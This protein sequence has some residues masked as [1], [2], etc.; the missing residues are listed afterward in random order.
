M[1][2]PPP[3]KTP[4]NRPDYETEVRPRS[5]RIS[6]RTLTFFL[7]AVLLL[8]FVAVSRNQS[9]TWKVSAHGMAS[10]K[11]GHSTPSEL[12]AA[13]G[14]PSMTWKQGATHR[15]FRFAGELWR[16][17]CPAG[18]AGIFKD[19]LCATYVGIANGHVQTLWTSDSRYHTGQASFIHAP[20]A[21]LR[22]N[23]NGTWS[24]WKAKC[25]SVIFPSDARATYLAPIL[26][27]SPDSQNG[28]ARAFYVSTVPA[29]FAPCA[30]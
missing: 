15:P 22:K 27:A 28:Y 7:I 8:G 11:I 19:Q 14:E 23:E 16:Y 30:P 20:I 29:L 3:T 17:A 13:W 12:R 18:I 21:Q 4:E 1:R 2:E 5:P 26:R 25:P 9:D 24:G 10:L 6:R